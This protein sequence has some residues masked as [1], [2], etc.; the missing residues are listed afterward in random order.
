MYQKMINLGLKEEEEAI[1]R[2]T[3]SSIKAKLSMPKELSK[4]IRTKWGGRGKG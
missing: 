1:M 2:D 3:S 4:V